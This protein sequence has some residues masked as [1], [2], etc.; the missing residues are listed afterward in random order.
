MAA[1]I[2]PSRLQSWLRPAFY[3]GHNALTLVGAVLTT[4]VS[5]VIC[6]PA[7]CGLARGR[8][9]DR[10]LI[11]LILIAP[12]LGIALV[13]FLTTMHAPAPPVETDRDS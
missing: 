7:A 10:Q 2:P 11:T 6:I 4:I 13:R 12:V 9:R 3:L 1:A 5:L 8:F